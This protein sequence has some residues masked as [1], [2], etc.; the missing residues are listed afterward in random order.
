MERAVEAPPVR[1]RLLFSDRHLLSKDQRAKGLRRC[2]A[3]LRRET[4]TVG[5]FGEHVKRLFGLRCGSADELFLSMG[6]F[7]LPPFESTCMFRDKDLIRVETSLSRKKKKKIAITDGSQAKEKEKIENQTILSIDNGENCEHKK[8]RQNE[9][10][11]KKSSKKKMKL[12]PHERPVVINASNNNRSSVTIAS[13][14]GGPINPVVLASD[15][16]QQIVVHANGSNEKNEHVSTFGKSVLSPLPSHL[17]PQGP[18]PSNW[19]AGQT[20][21]NNSNFKRN[22]WKPKNNYNS[23]DGSNRRNNWK[24]WKESNNQ[25]AINNINNINEEKNKGKNIVEN[26]EE[27][28]SDDDELDLERFYPLL[29]LPKEGDIIAYRLMDSSS[30]CLELS[31]FRVGEV[32]IFDPILMEIVLGSVSEYPIFPNGEIPKNSL[33]NEDGT[34]GIDFGDLV[35]LRLVKESR[36]KLPPKGNY[37]SGKMKSKGKGNN[38]KNANGNPDNNLEAGTGNDLANSGGNMN[39]NSAWETGEASNTR[40]TQQAEESG[41]GTWAPSKKRTNTFRPHAQQ[42]NDNNGFS[43]RGGF[44]RRN[45]NRGGGDN[46]RNSGW[47]TQE[48]ANGNETGQTQTQTQE[49]GW[50][51]WAPSNCRAGVTRSIVGQNGNF[52]ARGGFTHRGRG[53]NGRAGKYNNP[54]FGN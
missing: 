39:T 24:P 49:N 54:R 53:R 40:E 29:R 4:A 43:S 44:S 5:E 9:S 41:W 33:Y 52:G 6:G 11:K 27:E 47:E 8:K 21:H 42:T 2:W 46:Q 48:A 25:N 16:N 31:P 23:Q 17:M 13:Q 12:T 35:D 50:D 26:K 22:N 15:K 14:N 10:E 28:E 3:V 1:V 30:A 45:T 18:G 7:L 37:K 36:L 34:L 38:W 20:K 51:T 19:Q 32:L